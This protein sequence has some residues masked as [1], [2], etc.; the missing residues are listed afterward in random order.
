MADP[1]E[2]A[3]TV[4]AERFDALSINYA[5]AASGVETPPLPANADGTP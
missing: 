1:S 4:R 2:L 5:R 3:D